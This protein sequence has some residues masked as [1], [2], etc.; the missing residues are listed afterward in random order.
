M[1]TSF[2]KKKQTNVGLIEKKIYAVYK[3]T[4]WKIH[5]PPRGKKQSSS[6]YKEESISSCIHLERLKKNVTLLVKFF[7]A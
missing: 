5:C 7:D 4:G 6:I 3:A 1:S 2:F